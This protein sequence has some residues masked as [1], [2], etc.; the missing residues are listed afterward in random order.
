MKKNH[1]NSITL[2]IENFQDKEL[3][4]NISN[5]KNIT[6]LEQVFPEDE[7]FQTLFVASTE[8]LSFVEMTELC[9][10]ITELSP[11]TIT[12]EVSAARRHC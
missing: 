9:N 11:E 1:A 7:E 8:S 12:A 4:L 5:L 3:L 2:R 6:K 10:K